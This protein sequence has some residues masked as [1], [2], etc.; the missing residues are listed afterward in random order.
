MQITPNMQR[1]LDMHA[2]IGRFAWTHTN[3]VV[4]LRE[5]AEDYLKQ[6][7]G[8]FG[9]LC[10]VKQQLTRP[11]MT[12]SAHQ[13]AGVLN[14]LA[15]EVRKAQAAEAAAA[16]VVDLAEPET[17]LTFP[18]AR[19]VPQGTYTVVLKPNEK[20]ITLDVRQRGRRSVVG[21]LSGPDNE[22]D[23]VRFASIVDGVVTVYSSFHTYVRMID[24][25]KVLVSQEVGL[26]VMGEAY[27]L[28]SGRCYRCGLKLTVPVS[29]HRGLGPICA[30]KV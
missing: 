5:A 19:D 29:L 8:S 17:K 25:L 16:V 30:N 6:Y 13:V 3:G 14:S 4:W 26:E 2:N 22:R 18:A 28:R 20:H 21:F 7:E 12:L 23:F 9:F 24:A 15:V 11:G 10:S 27:A 1:A